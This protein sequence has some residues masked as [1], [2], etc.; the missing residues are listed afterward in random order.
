MKV[1]CSFFIFLTLFYHQVLHCEDFNNEE[2]SCF[3]NEK[4]AILP[5]QIT[6]GPEGIF[7]TDAS[8]ETF[9]VSALFS[10]SEGLFAFIVRGQPRECKACYH[11]YKGFYCMNPNCK[12]YRKRQ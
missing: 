11:E 10:T 7:L 2:L 12:L 4:I 3:E 6:V 5:D 1:F 8:G 9:Q